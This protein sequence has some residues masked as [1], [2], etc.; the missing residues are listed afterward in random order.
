MALTATAK[1]DTVEDMKDLLRHPH[2]VKA[3]VNRPNIY[4]SVEELPSSNKST[5][6]AM[7]FSRRAADI[8]GTSSAII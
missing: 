8:I 4:L 2:V 3:S 6:P 7:Q 1:P 5:P